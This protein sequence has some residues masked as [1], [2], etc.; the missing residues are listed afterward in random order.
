VLRRGV[1][2]S[3][4]GRGVPDY[5]CVSLSRHLQNAEV[6]ITNSKTEEYSCVAITFFYLYK[7]DY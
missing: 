7:K 6:S 1:Q 4:D 3:I 5:G 2:K